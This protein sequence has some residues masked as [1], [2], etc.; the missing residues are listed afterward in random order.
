MWPFV[1][2]RCPINICGQAWTPALEHRA[3]TR[4]GT[5]AES[6][7]HFLWLKGSR[8]AEAGSST[9]TGT[10]EH[11]TT[12]LGVG[13]SKSFRARQK[14]NKAGHFQTSLTASAHPRWFGSVWGPQ[15]LERTAPRHRRLSHSLAAVPPW[16]PPSREARRAHR[17]AS[18]GLVLACALADLAP[19][20]AH[21]D[22]HDTHRVDRP[23]ATRMIGSVIGRSEECRPSL[24]WRVGGSGYE[25]RRCLARR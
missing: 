19:G 6:H 25:T 12:N 20:R 4:R 15:F 3:H 1:S 7:R 5:P 10:S 11:R 14:T 13:G 16:V 17:R 9:S 8:R 21:A 23:G 24:R 22:G 18:Y 2:N